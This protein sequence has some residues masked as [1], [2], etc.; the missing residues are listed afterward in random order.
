MKGGSES[1]F[2]TVMDLWK[3]SAKASGFMNKK[4]SGDYVECSQAIPGKAKLRRQKGYSTYV[5]KAE[6]SLRVP[7]QQ[8]GFYVKKGLGR[9]A[10]KSVPALVLLWSRLD[11]K[12]KLLRMRLLLSRH[13]LIINVM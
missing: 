3:L 2:L 4:S 5:C 7:S 11:T 9:T 8:I 13:N 12:W 10:V 6:V 1:S